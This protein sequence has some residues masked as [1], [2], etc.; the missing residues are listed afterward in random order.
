MTSNSSARRRSGLSRGGLAGCWSMQAVSAGRTGLRYRSRAANCRHL[1]LRSTTSGALRLRRRR[2][3]ADI[4][5]A[6]ARV[7]QRRPTSTAYGISSVPAQDVRSRVGTPSDHERHKRDG[8]AVPA[9]ATQPRPVWW[10]QQLPERQDGRSIA[11]DVPTQ[12][13][14]PE[15]GGLACRKLTTDRDQQKQWQ[16]GSPRTG[17]KTRSR[18]PRPTCQRGAVGRG[19]LDV[20]YRAKDAF[21]ERRRMSRKHYA[22]AHVSCRDHTND[23]SHGEELRILVDVGFLAIRKR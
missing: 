1:A 9:T 16:A 21:H 18:S 19:R 22:A 7:L 17:R 13:H 4:I 10:A 3:P 15:R 23:G 11:A 5:T 20:S 8:Y 12:D 6:P 14:R 2:L